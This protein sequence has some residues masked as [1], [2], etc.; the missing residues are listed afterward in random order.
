LLYS[1]KD[2]A[3]KGVELYEVDRGGDVT[4]HAPGQLV[5]YPILNL[6]HYGQDL[7][8]YLN[9]LEQV[10][11]DLLS[12]FGIVADRIPG[13]TGVWV[14]KKKIVSIGIGVKKWV[15]F[16]GIGINVNTD[17]NYFSLIKP[18]GLDV[19]MT[20]M[21]SILKKEVDMDEVKA[22]AIRLLNRTFHVEIPG[23]NAQ[24]INS[25]TVGGVI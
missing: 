22:K 13:K 14:G 9:R 19:Q 21:K 25:H 17:L 1:K 2:I 15:S 23:A 5:I 20:S 6:A 4:L 8:S 24:G 10:A 18:C 12:E 3:Q 7:H 11:I 16:H